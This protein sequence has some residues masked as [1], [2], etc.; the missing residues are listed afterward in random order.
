M[1]QTC[2]V[3]SSFPQSSAE[4]PRSQAFWACLGEVWPAQTWGRAQS[5][6]DNQSSPWPPLFLR[7]LLGTPSSIRGLPCRSLVLGAPPI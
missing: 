6:C 1:K 2:P 3:S 5:T 7:C 4:T